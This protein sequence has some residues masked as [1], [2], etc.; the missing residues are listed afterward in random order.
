MPVPYKIWGSGI[1]SGAIEQL[2]RAA[3][4]PI[5]VRGALMPDAHQG[6]GLPIGGV[7][8]TKDA[9]IPYAVGVDIACRMKLTVFDVSPYIIGQKREKFRKVIEENTVFGA[10][11]QWK[12]PHDHAVMDDIGWQAIDI[13]RGLKDTAWKQLGTSGGGNHF[14]EFGELVVHE[15]V[16]GDDSGLSGEGSR[17]FGHIPP[18]K[19]LALLSHSG[20]RGFGARVAEY[21]SQIAMD[22]HPELD[23]AYRHLAWLDM[24]G[25]GGEYWKAMTLAGRYASANHA[26]IHQLIVDSLR[27][28]VLGGVE[29]H[30]NYAWKE[31]HDGQ[32]VIVHRKGSTP[33]GEGVYGVIPGSMT[34]PGFVVR[35]KGSSEAMNSAAHGAG[36]RMSRSQAFKSITW[37]QVEHKLKKA[38]VELLSASLDEAPN[39]YKDIHEVMAAQA[40]LVEVVAEFAPKMVKMADDGKVKRKHRRKR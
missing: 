8:A 6:Y 29:N 26:V 30:H 22:M 13:A 18:G 34:E 1:E 7:L 9:V 3:E 20:S 4:L 27:Y 11:R 25:L 23:K 2:E 38:E 35:G 17:T 12:T 15:T 24:K 39:A 36:R 37:E 10:G 31:V 5:A 14:V 28:D 40:D 16:D 21:Y 33:A 32:E 19:Y